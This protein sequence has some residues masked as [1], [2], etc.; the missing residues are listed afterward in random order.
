MSR[1]LSLEVV[2]DIFWVVLSGGY[3]AIAQ[4]YPPDSRLAPT[5]AGGTALV[6]GLVQLLGNLHGGLRRVTH[7]APA[8]TPER[9]TETAAG[10]SDDRRQLAAIAFTVG[11]L[12][13]VYV[14]GFLV[15]IPLFILLYFLFLYRRGWRFAVVSSAVVLVFVVL[16][17]Q[18]LGVHLPNGLIWDSLVG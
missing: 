6:V 14:L 8:S 2:V 7:G 18:V 4:T 13:G 10:S 16:V 1:R 12:V 3:V 5:V 9:S 17:V 11:L 15:G